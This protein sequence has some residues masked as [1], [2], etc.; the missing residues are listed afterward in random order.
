MNDIA[1]SGD[2]EPTACDDF[3]RAVEVCAEVRRR[4]KID[5]VKLV[6]ISN[7][8]LFHQ[9]RVRQALKIL[10]AN[11]GEIWAKLDA[12]TEDYYRQVDRSAAPWRRILDNLRDAAIER[13]IVVQSL[14]LRMHGEPMSQS[15]LAAYCDRL[16]EIT[17]A[18][19][20][21]KLVQA[22][23][24]AR[25]TAENWV[26]ALSDGEIEAVAE[27]VRQRTGLPVAAYYGG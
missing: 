22:H 13:P 20:R 25:R 15:E 14:F 5:D 6:L 12:G 27:T 10:D 18:G 23:T 8:T 19:G 1:L 11:N 21:I 7:A 17:S 26:T 24:I 16:N 2:G 4:R 3:D 9:P